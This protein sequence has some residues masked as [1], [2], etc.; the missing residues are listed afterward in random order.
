LRDSSLYQVEPDD[1]VIFVPV[2]YNPET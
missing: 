2:K 1:V